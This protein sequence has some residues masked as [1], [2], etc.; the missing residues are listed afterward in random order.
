[1]KLRY[2]LVGIALAML[3]GPAMANILPFSG[4]TVVGSSLYPGFDGTV[5]AGNLINGTSNPA[6]FNTDPRWVFADNSSSQTLIVNLG[7]SILINGAGYRYNGQDRIPTSFSLLTSTDGSTFNPVLGPIPTTVADYG[8]PIIY[9][10]SFS[11]GPTLA[12]YVE[13]N[14]GADSIGGF[15][16][17]GGPGQGPGIYQL[18][19]EAAPSRIPEPLT[20]SLFGVGLAG[21]AAL[22]RRQKK[23]A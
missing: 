13:F 16:G 2:L 5:A 4:D 7:S 18:A 22:R 17:G 20:L 12:Q 15:G 8:L 3:S 19:V 10:A 14:F 9:T 21:A 11:F 23:A 1:M 6:Y